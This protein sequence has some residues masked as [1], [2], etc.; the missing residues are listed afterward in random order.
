MKENKDD[1]FSILCTRM[2]N[3]LEI[4]NQEDPMDDYYGFQSDRYS[5]AK[6]FADKV[7]AECG[8][9][10]SQFLAELRERVSPKWIHVTG[11][12]LLVEDE[13]EPSER[14]VANYRAARL[15][16]SGVVEMLGRKA[17]YQ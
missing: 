5:L 16:E 12:D 8:Y 2:R 14:A 4:M 9:T 1:R 11:M 17:V 15:S 6:R 7:L 10:G 3:V 13:C